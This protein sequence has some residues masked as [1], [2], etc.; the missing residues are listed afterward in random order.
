[1]AQRPP[2]AKR[3][4]R[5]YCATAQALDLVGE[6][7]TLLIVR[8]LLVGPRRFSDFLAAL[9]GIGPNLLTMRLKSLEAADIVEREF[10]PPPAASRVYRLTRLGRELDPVVFGLARF[11]LRLLGPPQPGDVFRPASLLLALRV[12]FDSEAAG[13]LD[14]LYELRVDGDTIWVRVSGG[15]VETGAGPVPAGGV[16]PVVL[17][18][19]G[20]SL[21]AVAAGTLSPQQ[22]LAEDRVVVEGPR[23]DFLRFFRLF[24]LPYPLPAT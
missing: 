2:A 11:G 3:S 18:I 12:T 5:Q 14:A 22:A 23:R 24:S 15:S 9:D 20:E 10:L 8:E 4:Y 21:L 7:W 19:S 1:M 17:T 6:R 13:D 16:A